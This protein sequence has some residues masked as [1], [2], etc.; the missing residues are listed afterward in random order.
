[1]SHYSLRTSAAAVLLAAWAMLPV[2]ANAQKAADCPINHDQLTQM[3]KQSVK[4][5]GGPD[6][7]GMSVNE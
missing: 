7:G 4:A 6:E 2:T 1:M 5:S 3:L